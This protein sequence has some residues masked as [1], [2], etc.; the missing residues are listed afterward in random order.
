MLALAAASSSSEVID[1]VEEH[2]AAL[3]PGTAAARLLL[4]VKARA[5]AGA[6]TSAEQG[7]GTR[8]EAPSYRLL[9]GS[10]QVEGNAELHAALDSGEIVVEIAEE[11][12]SGWRAEHEEGGGG[13]C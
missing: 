8:P 12:V 1:V 13:V 9:G 3:V 11:G 7:Q 6:D 2:A 10:V 5:G 4:C